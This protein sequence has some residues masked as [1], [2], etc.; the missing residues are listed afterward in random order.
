MLYIPGCVMIVPPMAKL[1]CERNTIAFLSGSV[2]AVVLVGGVSVMDSAK[3]IA[4]GYYHESDLWGYLKG[5]ES[6]GLERL[7]LALIPT[8]PSNGLE[9]GLGA[10]FVDSRN[11]DFGT[12]YPPTML[13]FVPNTP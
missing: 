7:P 3:L 4:F 12:A 6:Y 11:G 8:C 2:V 5:K 10:V 1:P 13:Y 9:N